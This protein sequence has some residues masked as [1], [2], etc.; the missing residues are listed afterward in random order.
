MEKLAMT[1]ITLWICWPSKQYT[2]KRH[3]KWRRSGCVP[4]VCR[5]KTWPLFVVPLSIPVHTSA[6]WSLEPCFGQQTKQVMFNSIVYT[7][8]YIVTALLFC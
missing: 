4:R 5:T 2:S 1:V 3:T 8:I 7:G 6:I